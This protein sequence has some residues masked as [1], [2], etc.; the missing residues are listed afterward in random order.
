MK[1]NYE[2]ELIGATES[3]IKGNYINL[4]G[5]IKLGSDIVSVFFFIKGVES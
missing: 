5:S 3:V 1:N 4:S 2:N